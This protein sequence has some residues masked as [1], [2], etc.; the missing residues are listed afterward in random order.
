MAASFPGSL[1]SFTPVDDGVTYV[2]QDLWN[3]AYNEIEAEQA[4]LGTFNGGLTYNES[5]K[6]LLLNYQQGCEVEF[7]SIADLYV[8][9]GELAIPDASSNLR[10]RRNPTDTT[11]NWTNIDTGAE[12]SGVETTY[13]VYAV[14]DAAATTFT[15]MISV[16]APATFAAATFFKQIGTFVNNVGN[17]IDQINSLRSEISTAEKVGFWANFNGDTFATRDSYNVTSISDEGTGDY[18]ITIA[19]DFANTDFCAVCSCT[20][21]ALASRDDITVGVFNVQTVNASGTPV[22]DTNVNV[23]A[24]G[25][26]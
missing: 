6:N 20:N 11:V 23:I 9:A 3:D 19:T 10:I 26:R 7:K 15:V 25:D 5:I 13:Y 1:K 24:I 14:A 16:T 21:V 22:D 8:R 4:L 12:S 2:E 18:N 17:D